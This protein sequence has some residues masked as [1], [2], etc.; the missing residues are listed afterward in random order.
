M[1]RINI[2]FLLGILCSFVYSCSNL[3]EK[4]DTS[5]GRFQIVLNAGIDTKVSG[6]QFDIEDKIGF[7]CVE[8][9]ST[10]QENFMGV[11]HHNNVLLTMTKTGL[12]SESPLFYPS[13]YESGSDLYAYYPYS[14]QALEF[15]EKDFNFSV[16]RDQTM[17]TKYAMSDFMLAQVLNVPKS[18]VP[19][20]ISFQRKMSKIEMVLIPGNGYNENVEGLLLA[21][22]TVKNVYLTSATDFATGEVGFLSNMQDIIPHGKFTNDGTEASGVHAIVPPQTIR[23]GMMLIQ[24][25][26]RGRKFNA[27]LEDDLTLLP[28]KKYVFKMKIDRDV[29]GSNITISPAI[30][31]WVDGPDFNG[32]TEEIDPDEDNK[33]L[34]D[35]DGN[36]YNTVKIGSQVWMGSNLAVTRFNDGS[37]IV[38]TEDLETWKGYGNT[39]EPGYCYYDNDKKYAPTYGALY[40]WFVVKSDKICPQG[41]RVPSADDWKELVNVLGADSGTRL[42]ST[43]GWYD[44]HGN[45]KPEYQG[46]NDC[47]FNALPCGNR[48][49]NNDYERATMYGE[50]WSSNVD[51]KYI[52]SAVVFFVAG[53]YPDIRSISHLKEHGHAI[54]C[55]KN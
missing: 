1:K 47:G 14:E 7:Y 9:V 20:T 46:T 4:E 17:D 23:K 51:E 34:T 18:P 10:P 12:R 54:R 44:V 42:K 15:T 2:L 29:A 32:I 26:L 36:E 49:V 21:T 52:Y 41:W 13:L 25:D 27:V 24:V 19:V 37:P 39:E 40:N 35:I 43:S 38:L 3:V 6:S 53:P 50:W 30:V 8:S 5:D 45:T 48:N 33:W 28:E 16:E 11:R 31:D 22:A 55:I